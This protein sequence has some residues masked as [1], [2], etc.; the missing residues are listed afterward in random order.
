MYCNMKK[1]IA[2]L[3]IIFCNMNI[4][5]QKIINEKLI[6][7]HNNQGKWG[8]LD[9]DS[10]KI[11]IAP[12]YDFA[13]L[14]ENGIALVENNNPNAT[15]L[16]NKYVKGYIRESGEEILPVNFRAIYDVKDFND[17]IIT[18]LKFIA[19][20][21]ETNGILKLPE[22]KWLVEPGK[23]KDFRF[24][25]VNQ[26]LADAIDFFDDG[27]KYSAPNGCNI[28]HV[29]FENR[30]FDITK[31]ENE[32][33]SGVCTWEGKIIVAPKYI[34]VQYFEKTKTFLAS[35]VTGLLTWKNIDK[36]LLDNFLF[37]ENGKQIVTFKSD[38]IPFVRENETVGRFEIKNKETYVDLQTGQFIAEPKFEDE[39]KQTIFQDM[40]TALFGLKA[41]DGKIL[42][43]PI[44]ST[45]KFLRNND[46]LKAQNTTYKYGIIDA[47]G[48]IQVPFDYDEL[49]FQNIVT[50]IAKKN[51]KY[52]T[53]NF[54]NQIRV[55]F[56][57]TYNLDFSNG[58]AIAT[59][60]LLKGVID[61]YGKIIVP[62]EYEDITK[63]EITN[64]ILKA[65]LTIINQTISYFSVKKNKKY[66]LYDQYSQLLIPLE[67]GYIREAN[68][69]TDLQK[70]WFQTADLQ[71]DKRGLVNVRSNVT[72]PPI[73]N[74]IK[75]FDDFLD[76]STLIDNNYTHQLLNLEGKPISEIV[77]DKMEF[78][79]GYFIVEKNKLQG[80]INT[81]GK[82]LV[83]LKFNFI[84]AETSNLIRIWDNER[85]YYINVNTGKE[86][87]S[88]E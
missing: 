50:L 67:Y 48:V 24:Y 8:Y 18:N 29:D 57:Y 34:D 54:S 4:F 70:G 5:A 40:K 46:F 66:G 52:G 88:K 81:K 28:K 1:P 61:I 2:F 68:S 80:I 58:F 84:W 36:K 17:S 6:P 86:Y 47:K 27:K 11:M 62:R 75:I 14:F 31:G 78:T 12:K 76:A 42:I 79:N 21:N 69:A 74:S 13:D 20:D 63:I 71:R 87:R 45:L 16:D 41:A 39:P 77:Y 32:P 37:D 85:Y 15:T 10:D 30:F 35:T 7:F 83:P 25:T 65:D 49:Y 22:G 33:N 51:G 72:I 55:D 73:Y 44:Y 26:F 59:K 23:Y 43:K 53:I 19:L 60:D 56:L 9:A 38:K 64:E 3:I 82:I